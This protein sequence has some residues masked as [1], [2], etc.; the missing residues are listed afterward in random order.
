MLRSRVL[1][2]AVVASLAGAV[3]ASSAPLQVLVTNDDGVRAAGIAQITTA[4]TAE[5]DVA[6][7]VVAPA[8]NQSG[9]GGRTTAG[10]LTGYATT[11]RSGYPAFAVKG[12]PADSVRYALDT[13]H[14][15][16]DV[17]ISGINDGANL[18][19]VVDLSGTVGAARAAAKRG[20]PALATS[21]GSG[22]PARFAD[23]V[24]ATI[25][26]FR[27]QRGQ[28][29]SGT[30]A[31]LNIPTCRFDGKPA[32]TASVRAA[33]AITLDFLKTFAPQPCP[34]KPGAPASDDVRAYLQGY[35]TLT[36]LPVR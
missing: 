28:L 7:T 32:G 31:N 24:T 25:G 11:T 23:G 18:G 36:P 6:V 27:A 29:V 3:P 35:A 10:T 34:A 9:T 2:V 22:R 15:T 16:P 12:T 5:P 20:L 26:W 19:P 33:G 8:T 17:V 4:L 1:S 21:Q 13:L 30:V 14:A